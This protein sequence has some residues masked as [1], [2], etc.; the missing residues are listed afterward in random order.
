MRRRPKWNVLPEDVSRHVLRRWVEGVPHEVIADELGIALTTVY[1]VVR[2]HGGVF[3][4]EDWHTTEARLSLDDRVE[5]RS[6]LDRGLSYNAIGV[7]IGFDKSTVCR[8]LLRNGGRDAYRPVEAHRASYER[9][10][11]PKPTK[12]SCDEK[13]RDK[14]AE[15][16]ECFWSPR[17]IA[18]WLRAEFGDDSSMQISHE[19][20]YKSL[21]VQGRGELRREL[22]RCLRTGRAKRATHNRR[23]NSPGRIPDMVMISERP[24]EVEDRAVPGHWEGDLILGQ[25]GKSAVGTL[26]ERHTRFVMLLHLDGERTAESVRLAMQAKIATLPNAL[27]RSITWD[28]GGEM[29]QHAQ[30]TVDTGVPVYFCDPHSPWQRGSNENTNGLLRQYMPKGTDLS[31]HTPDD[32][33]R[34]ADSLN[35]RP[36]E[37]LNWQT[38]AKRL[39]DVI[40]AMTG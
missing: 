15:K 31:Q 34:I 35:T 18:R 23:T 1:T 3:R 17:Q 19:T 16:L 8:E 2:P 21:Y 30:F 13:L 20:I 25:G 39:N 32:L 7:L 9:A 24:A 11:R 12:L 4:P 26:V 38:P 5:I 33:D 36:R 6:G 22:A 10:K 27:C 28:Q 40:V 29:A 14:V 37:T